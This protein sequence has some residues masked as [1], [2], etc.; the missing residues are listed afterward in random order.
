MRKPWLIILSLGLGALLAGG[1]GGGDDTDPCEGLTLCATDGELQCNSGGTGILICGADAEGCL[2]WSESS[3]CGA[4]QACDDSG[5]EPTCVCNDTC[6]TE[7]ATQC[8]GDAVQTCTTDADGCLAWANTTNCADTNEAC[9]NGACEGGTTCTDGDTRCEDNMVQT[10][11]TNTWTMSRD[12]DTTGQTCQVTEGVAECQGPIACEPACDASLCMECDTSVG[13]CVT[14]CEEWQI[15]NNGVCEASGDCRPITGTGEVATGNNAS[16]TD[17]EIGSCGGDGGLDVVYCWTAPSTGL[18]SADTF[19]TIHDTVL[20]VF[21]DAGDELDCDDDAAETRQSRVFFDTTQGMVYDI[22]VDAYGVDDAGPFLLNINEVAGEDVCD[23]FEDND[24]DGLVDCADP[25]ACGGLSADCAPGEGLPSDACTAHSD[26]AANLDDPACL[27]EEFNWAGGYCT[28]WCD[29]ADDD[30][31]EGYLCLS[32]ENMGFEFGTLGLC[33]ATCTAGTECPDRTLDIGSGEFVGYDCLVAPGVAEPLCLPDW[34]TIDWGWCTIDE[35][36]D[37]CGNFLDEDCDGLIDCADDDNTC[38]NCT[39]GA[40]ATGAACTANTDCAANLN[41]PACLR[42]YMGF[43]GGMC[44]EWCI[45]SAQDCGDNAFCYDWGDG[46][47]RGQ[48]VTTCTAS[49]DCPDR[50]TEDYNWGCYGDPDSD[51]QAC[52][53]NWMADSGWTL[54]E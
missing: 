20:Y 12:C 48:C 49:S 7:N 5:A 4:R 8:A 14:A 42:E 36:E 3:S 33:M 28:E 47:D 13:N 53:P 25:S 31:G 23:D 44:S 1:C 24:F 45:L 15:C 16:A 19:G 17:D 40:G 6:N 22:V 21:D 10:C 34:W 54:I 39:P 27:P 32:F 37:N 9:V 50:T 35:V 26:C 41:D 52:L 43:P 2:V 30:C 11:A 29:L 38:D 51:L 46:V 18:F